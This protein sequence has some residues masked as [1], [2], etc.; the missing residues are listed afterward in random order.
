LVH[1]FAKQESA[2]RATV[3]DANHY[4]LPGRVPPDSLCRYWRLLNPHGLWK[5]KDDQQTLPATSTHPCGIADGD[6]NTFS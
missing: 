6:Y 4:L 3:P 1:H 5:V 2:F